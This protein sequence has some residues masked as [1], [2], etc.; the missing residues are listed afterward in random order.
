M[1]LVSDM[2]AECDGLEVLRFE[3]L[4]DA[5]RDA[6]KLVGEDELRM[7]SQRGRLEH[8]HDVPQAV[9]LS[10][11]SFQSRSLCVRTIHCLGHF[12][13]LQA[14]AERERSQVFEDVGVLLIF[15]NRIIAGVGFLELGLH[16]AEDLDEF[17]FLRRLLEPHDST[18]LDSFSDDTGNEAEGQLLNGRRILIAQL[19]DLLAEPFAERPPTE[20]KLFASR[21]FLPQIG[22][23]HMHDRRHAVG[24]ERH[25]DRRAFRRTDGQRRLPRK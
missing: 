20:S 1:K 24:H 16:L 13:L 21:P 15:V 17:R 5:I 19:F 14:W 3:E 18:H 7:C 8:Q 25:V 12:G 23:A 2:Q 10:Q 11:Q 4:D 6:A 22:R 9:G